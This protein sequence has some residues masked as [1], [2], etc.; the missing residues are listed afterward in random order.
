MNRRQILTI[1]LGLVMVFNG[2]Y[3]VVQCITATEFRPDLN[4]ASAIVVLLTGLVIIIFLYKN[5]KNCVIASLMAVGASMVL[6]NVYLLVEPVQSIELLT[7]DAHLII[8]VIL[9][10]YALSLILHT[11]AGS[12]K[13][14][15][16]LGILAFTEFLPFIYYVYMGSNIVDTLSAH[17][18]S[19]V[20]GLMHLAILL[21]LTRKDMLLEGVSSRLTRN[22]R[23]LYRSM[24]TP[25]DAYIDV[26][27]VN[28]LM[29][30]TEEGWTDLSLGPVLKEKQVKLHNSDMEILLQ[31]MNDDDRTYISLRPVRNGSFSI[32][33]S[34]PIEKV[35]LN[36]NEPGASGM[37]RVY[38]TD[39]LFMDILVKDYNDERKTYIETIRYKRRK[40]RTRS[41]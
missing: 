9:V 40:S 1:I 12:A 39:G 23:D 4:F 37:I 15:L 8:S 34:F 35:V 6:R 11:S 22:S 18:N 41:S 26:N 7:G 13:A 10:Y 24:C 17:M 20:Y 19:L 30:D 31:K 2:T 32:P 33:V 21:I 27:D 38:G 29:T 36:E 3:F 14:L 5:L 16:C 28:V 25:A